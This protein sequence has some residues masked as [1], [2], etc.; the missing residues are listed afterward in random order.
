MVVAAGE[1]RT[2]P[3]AGS[4]C[5]TPLSMATV[6]AFETSQDRVAEPPCTIAEGEAAKEFTVGFSTGDDTVREAVAIVSPASLA[7]VRV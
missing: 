1:T 3:D 2:V 4:T 6:A 5:P 7:A